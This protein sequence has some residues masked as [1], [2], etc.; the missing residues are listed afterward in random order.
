MSANIEVASAIDRQPSRST[1]LHWSARTTRRLASPVLP[2][3]PLPFFKYLRVSQDN[4]VAGFHEGLASEPIYERKFLWFRS[5]IVNDP[6]G[7]KRVLM[8]NRSNYTKADILRPV[9]GPALGTGLVTSD[10]ETWR[11]LRRLIAPV[12]DP[13]SVDGYGPIMTE[14]TRSVLARWLARPNGSTVDINKAMGGLAL[15]IISRAMFSSDS[16]EMAE[17]IER[18]STE[19]QQ[20][21]TFSFCGFV[22]VIN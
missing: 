13:R 14:A 17:V 21:M 10:G 19:Y 20:R 15:E 22:P 7:I 11:S 16:A 18:S 9:L 5:F 2:K 4:F 6:S 3:M 12:F 8:E 1:N